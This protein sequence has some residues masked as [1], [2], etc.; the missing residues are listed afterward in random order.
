MLFLPQHNKTS[1]TVVPTRYALEYTVLVSVLSSKN[2][3]MKKS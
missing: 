3:L 1:C 2:Y